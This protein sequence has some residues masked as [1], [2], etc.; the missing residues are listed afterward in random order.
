MVVAMAAFA[1]E[2]ML[3]KLMS[4]GLPMGQ[5]V[6]M[7][8]IGGTLFFGVLTRVR[9]H[10]IWSP[11]ILTRPIL[12]RNLGEMIATAGYVSAIVLT[13]LS[14][15]SAILQAT[16]LAVTL[17]AAL[18]LGEPV[19]WRR[20]SAIV[21]G[22]IGVLLIIRPGLEGFAPASLFAVMAVAGLALRD[23]S[24]RAVPRDVTSA[25]ISVW[26][27][28]SVIPTGILMMLVMG[29]PA[30]VPAWPDIGRMAGA[31]TVGVLGYYSLVAATRAGDVAVVVPFRYSRLIFAMIIGIIVF[32]ERPDAL[33]LAGATLVVCAGLYT[34]WRETRP[35]TPPAPESTGWN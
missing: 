3:I 12:L 5:V 32:G 20:W 1:L 33:M 10:R 6:L 14:G 24:V 8:G 21:V 18:F 34:I 30:E 31:I 28:L 22:F 26:A 17:G 19:G 16:P 29:T 13:T 25:Q 9:G 7:L 35:V 2:D 4:S 11:V 23:L 15:A 27:F